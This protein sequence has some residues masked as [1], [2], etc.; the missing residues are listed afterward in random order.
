M[1]EGSHS[2]RQAM[3]C[4]KRPGC[5][6]IGQEVRRFISDNFLLEEGYDPEETVSLLESGVMD[7]TGILELVAFIERTY[8]FKIADEELIPENL[9]TIKG[10]VGFIAGRMM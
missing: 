1:E 4:G 5:E 7:S 10:I 8:R 6:E 9:D 2:M 3:I